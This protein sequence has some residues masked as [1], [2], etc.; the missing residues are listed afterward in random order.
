MLLLYGVC[1]VMVVVVIILCFD[2]L[3]ELLCW[4]LFCCVCV[5]LKLLFVFRR[6]VVMCWMCLLWRFWKM[7]VSV[8]LLKCRSCRICVICVLR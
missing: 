5:W 6:F 4:I 1:V 2:C 7:S 3:K 8:W